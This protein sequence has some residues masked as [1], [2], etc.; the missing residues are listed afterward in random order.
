MAGKLFLIIF[1]SFRQASTVGPMYARRFAWFQ[2]SFPACDLADSA[3][4]LSD[5]R[6]QATGALRT[7]PPVDA[8]RSRPKEND[9]A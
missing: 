1:C 5:A 7:M 9:H 6:K 4:F 2:N 8:A 3:K